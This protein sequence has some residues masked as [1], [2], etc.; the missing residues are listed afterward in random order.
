MVFLRI[1]FVTEPNDACKPGVAGFTLWDKIVIV[2][3]F[4]YI[5]FIF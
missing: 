3:I 5:T 1:W 2:A 4:C